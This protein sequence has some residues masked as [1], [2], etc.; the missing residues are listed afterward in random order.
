[1]APTFMKKLERILKNNVGLSFVEILAAITMLAI[2]VGP[3]MNSFISTAKLNKQTRQLMGA[4]E[5]AEDIMEGFADKSM[6]QIKTIYNGGLGTSELDLSSINPIDANGDGIPDGGA[7]NAINAGKQLS[8]GFSCTPGGSTVGSYSAS[9]VD[10]ANTAPG[11]NGQSFALGAIHTW[12]GAVAGAIAGDEATYGAGKKVL[13]M[14][15]DDPSKPMGIFF[16]YCNVEWEGYTYDVLGYVLPAGT[17]EEASYY[18]C[19]IR[20]AVFEVKN[21]VH[22]CG[23]PTSNSVVTLDSG[24]RNK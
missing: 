10:L 23:D 20:I 21:N 13:Y 12:G 11:T 2:I 17:K 19:A 5:V 3:I 9:G 8:F 6:A 7:F 22:T 4:T 18:P 1:M 15:A 24:I 14:A 16:A